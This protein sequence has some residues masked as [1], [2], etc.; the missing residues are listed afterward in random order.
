[1]GWKTEYYN[2][3]Q[4]DEYPLTVADRMYAKPIIRDSVWR[5]VIKSPLINKK[6]K[7]GTY[8]FVYSDLGLMI[9]HHLVERVNSQPLDSFTSKY[10]YEPMGMNSTGF[11]PLRKITKTQIAPTENDNLFRD[12]LL[13]GTVQD[14]TAAM[15][16]GVSGHAGLFSNATDLAKLLQTLH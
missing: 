7:D 16:G 15:L 14:Q 3:K 5:W 6:E 12:R 2:S 9:L 10:F 1:M 11:N 4:S 13:Q 8:P